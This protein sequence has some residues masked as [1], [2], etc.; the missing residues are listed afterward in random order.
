MSSV[1]TIDFVHER[2]SPQEQKLPLKPI[3]ILIWAI[4]MP[5][6]K[7]LVGAPEHVLLRIK[8]IKESPILMAG[9]RIARARGAL[10]KYGCGMKDRCGKSRL[11]DM[12]HFSGLN[13]TI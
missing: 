5:K 12:Y 8:R 13:V 11:T 9:H 3:W 7:S 2:N 10:H 4:H 1:L 6:Y